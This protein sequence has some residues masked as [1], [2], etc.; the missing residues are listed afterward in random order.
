MLT[1]IEPI[2]QTQ[3]NYQISP[4]SMSKQSSAV[5]TR[6]TWVA[7]PPTTTTTSAFLFIL[8]FALNIVSLAVASDV[9]NSIV[10]YPFCG[11]SICFLPKNT[12]RVRSLAR[13]CH[14]GQTT[15]TPKRCTDIR[16]LPK[17]IDISELKG[18]L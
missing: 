5:K 12:H 13:W 2:T 18:L 3:K 11:E 7:F 1:F 15:H 4:Q 17:R 8:I 14:V 6:H 10:V 9:L 16:Y